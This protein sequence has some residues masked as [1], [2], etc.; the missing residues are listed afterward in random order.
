[1]AYQPQAPQLEHL[2]RQLR[3]C[4]TTF[5]VIFFAQVACLILAFATKLYPHF[6]V[7][8]LP[9]LVASWS[10]FVIRQRI[11]RKIQWWRHNMVFTELIDKAVF[12]NGTG[13]PDYLFYL[14][15][16]MADGNVRRR[17]ERVSPDRYNQTLVGRRW[18]NQE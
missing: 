18:I 4:Y 7:I 3:R 1:M 17:V 10:M 12:D 5:E 14:D 16:L 13:K 2:E 8:L 9:L 15:L 11:N 6:L